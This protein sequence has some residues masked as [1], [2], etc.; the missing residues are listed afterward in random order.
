MSET[1]SPRPCRWRSSSRRGREAPTPQGSFVIETLPQF[2]ALDP[3]ANF[4][5]AVNQDTGTVVTFRV[6]QRNRRL[7]PTGQI[8]ND[9]LHWCIS[10]SARSRRLLRPRGSRA[11]NGTRSPSDLGGLP[12][13]ETQPSGQSGQSC[14]RSAADRTTCRM[15]HAPVGAAGGA[16]SNLA[17]GACPSWSPLRAVAAIR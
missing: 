7:T 15:R 17:N 8:V 1:N 11:H 14:H 13:P 9:C 12:A 10:S 4:L 6:N 2:S 16:A 5:F 3:T